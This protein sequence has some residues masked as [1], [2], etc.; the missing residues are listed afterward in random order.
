MR[1][2]KIAFSDKYWS[3]KNQFTIRTFGIL[4][5]IAIIKKNY[6]FEFTKAKLNKKSEKFSQALKFVKGNNN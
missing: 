6:N 4:S 1:N 2:G 3:D 5:R